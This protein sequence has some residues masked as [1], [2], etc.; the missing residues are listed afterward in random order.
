MIMEK[1]WL[2]TQESN[3]D[4]LYMC[5]AIPCSSEETA[6]EMMRRERD[7]ILSESIHYKSHSKDDFKVEDDDVHFFIQ[8]L[9]DEYYEYLTIEEK[10]IQY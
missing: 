10:T 4:G 6:R 7:T 5:N 9:Y 1:I 2:L 8:D 3:V